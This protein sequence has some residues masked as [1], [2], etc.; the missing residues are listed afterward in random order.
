MPSGYTAG[1]ANGTITTLNE[2]ARTCIR[3]MG[4]CIAL[5]DEPQ[6]VPI[7]SEI[8]PRID[9]YDEQ[10]E[11]AAKKI[12][13][14]LQADQAEL[15]KQ[16][17]EEWVMEQ[18]TILTRRHD[19]IVQ[20]GRYQALLD[21]VQKWEVPAEDSEQLFA[22]LK[23][24]MVDQL[25]ESIKFDCFPNTLDEYYA[26]TDQPTDVS[27]WLNEKLEAHRD[28]IKYY[29]KRRDEEIARAAKITA[30]LRQFNEV[31]PNG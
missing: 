23:K 3:A 22:N 13:D 19:I 26:L 31:F 24:F 17:Y 21:E 9:H 1:V 5:R 11:A 7:P 4:V 25:T 28:T 2:F 29:T 30:L 8:S 15:E 18:G 14:L 20:Q 16:M 6:G 10:I 12:T 27:K